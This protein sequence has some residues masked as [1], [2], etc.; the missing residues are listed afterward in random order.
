M[1]NATHKN[2]VVKMKTSN[3]AR[4]AALTALGLLAGE[5]S[6]TAVSYYGAIFDLAIA[7]TGAPGGT[8][9]VTYTAN[10]TN[11]TN[12]A[13]QPY[14]SAI[15]WKHAGEDVLSASLTADPGDGWITHADSVVNANG[16]SGSGGNTWACA[17]DVT[18]PYVATSG[19]L[20]WVFNATFSDSLI[21]NLSTTGDSIKA[22]FVDRWGNKEGSLLS[23]TLNGN[24]Q[25]NCSSTSVPEPASVLLMGLGLLGIGLAR[26]RQ[27]KSNTKA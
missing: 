21:E 3:I 6:A 23:C 10:F 16:C 22:M 7:D 11:F 8:Y 14:I 4:L 9:Q 24:T 13:Q 15:S 12:G 20:T 19:L 5:A 1:I 2:M 17:Q 27:M 25:D 18:S 26:A